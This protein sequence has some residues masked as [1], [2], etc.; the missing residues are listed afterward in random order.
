[1]PHFG[2]EAP[3]WTKLEFT[4]VSHRSAPYPFGLQGLPG[5]PMQQRYG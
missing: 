5:T 3:I 4:I 2:S 1:M